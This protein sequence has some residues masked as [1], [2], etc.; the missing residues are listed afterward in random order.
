MT[1]V[2]WK[3]RFP[4][5]PSSSRHQSDLPSPPPPFPSSFK[6]TITIPICCLFRLTMKTN[7]KL[8]VLVEDTRHE[9]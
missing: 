4:S 1:Q 3:K 5:P 2:T 6:H 7:Q 8:G 9:W